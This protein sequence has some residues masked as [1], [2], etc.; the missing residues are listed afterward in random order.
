M[1]R[2]ASSPFGLLTDWDQ[3]IR[4]ILTDNSIKEPQSPFGLLTDWDQ[5]AN[6]G[7]NALEKIVS[8]A[9]RLADGFGL[10]LS[11]QQGEEALRVSIAFRLADGFGL[12]TASRRRG[13]GTPSQSPFGLLT[14][15]DGFD[16]QVAKTGIIV[17]SQSP[18][19]LLTDWDLGSLLHSPQPGEVSIAFR[20]ADGLG[21][22]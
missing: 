12:S 1:R 13:G 20:L 15:S 18:F 6:H 17:A 10:V 4:K 19:G 14:D 11:G 16:G 8:I 9:F 21:L 7:K 3:D 5:E 22:G 2:H